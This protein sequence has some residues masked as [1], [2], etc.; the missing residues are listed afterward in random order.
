MKYKSFKVQGKQLQLKP[1]TIGQVKKFISVI[2]D[3]EIDEKMVVADLISK[4]I[5]EKL[6]E[7]MEI[8]FP[9]Q[10]AKNIKWD[11]VEYDTFDEIIEHFLSLN[12]RLTERL[13]NL[14]KNLDLLE[15]E[16]TPS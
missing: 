9:K 4:I 16:T 6:T 11:E 14:L 10:G 2:K 13:R 8:I 5:D 7:F 3:L 12:P 1:L 15:T